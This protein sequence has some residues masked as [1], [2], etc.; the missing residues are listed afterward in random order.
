MCYYVGNDVMMKYNAE[1]LPT[2]AIKLVLTGCLFSLPYRGCEV[3]N[4]G[5]A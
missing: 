2:F 3:S 1:G 5:Q 4:F